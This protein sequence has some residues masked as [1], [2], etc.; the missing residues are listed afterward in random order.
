MIILDKQENEKIIKKSHPFYIVQ[1]SAYG[2]FI[3]VF[4]G[5]MAFYLVDYFHTGNAEQ[6]QEYFFYFAG[7][8][9]T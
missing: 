6:F 8:I 5:L 3:C 7:T 4:A 9:G 1:P 2:V